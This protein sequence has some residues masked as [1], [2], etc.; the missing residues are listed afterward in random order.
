MAKIET[1]G[2]AKKQ[3]L[4]SRLEDILSN[5]LV[6]FMK[7]D[8]ITLQT[9]LPIISNKDTIDTPQEAPSEYYQNQALYHH[10]LHI[11]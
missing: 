2:V 3:S 1:F 9:Q 6:S 11:S 4:A 7:P 10:L 5:L 8:E